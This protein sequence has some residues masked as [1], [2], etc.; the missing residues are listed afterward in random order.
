MP[1]QKEL[2]DRYGDN[3]SVTSND[4]AIIQRDEA[5]NMSSDLTDTIYIE[6][7]TW[8]YD[9]DSINQINFTLGA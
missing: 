2:N 9:N 1:T 7:V 3:L 5:G 4:A 8:A 6:P